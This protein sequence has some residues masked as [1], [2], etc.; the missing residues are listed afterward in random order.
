MQSGEQVGVRQRERGDKPP[1]RVAV[2]RLRAEHELQRLEPASAGD[3]DVQ[4]GARAF[5]GK[6]PRRRDRR[7]DRPDPADDAPCSLHGHELALR[8]RDDEHRR[9]RGM[10]SGSRGHSGEP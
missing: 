9:N 6:R 1:R 3:A 2:D 8:R 10:G 5:L 4:D 7:L